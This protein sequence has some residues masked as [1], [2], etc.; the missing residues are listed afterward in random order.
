VGTSEAEVVEQLGDGGGQRG[1]RRLDVRRHG[2][3]VAESWQVDRDDSEVRGKRRND[4]APGV[5]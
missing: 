3:G 5:A 4:G 1:G 2:P